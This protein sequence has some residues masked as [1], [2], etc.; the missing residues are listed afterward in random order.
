MLI[1]SKG[2]VM[3][4][5][6]E[7]IRRPSPDVDY[8]AKSKYRTV[9]IVLG[10]V[11]LPIA[12]VA[13]AANLTAAGDLSTGD[14]TDAAKILGWS[15]GANTLAFMALKVGIAVTLILGTIPA[16]LRAGGGEAQLAAGVSVKTLKMPATAKAFI[17]LMAVGMMAAM[18]Q[19]VG[20]AIAAAGS[21]SAFAAWSAWLGPLREAAL[22]LL[23]AGIVLA[24]VTIG[25][26]LGFQFRRINEII[27]T[28]R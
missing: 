10:A 25:N 5:S 1:L 24:L 16:G 20:Y 13:V 27:S 3:T 21:A 19:L 6:L 18:A 2:D 8:R 12:G 4:A 22:G 9:G 11:G 7:V 15:F 23:L 26:V 14:P 28:G 17:V